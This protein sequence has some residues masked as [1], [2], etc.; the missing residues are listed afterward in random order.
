MRWAN[1]I[2]KIKNMVILKKGQ[3]VPNIKKLSRQQKFNEGEV[4]QAD[5]MTK[6]GCKSSH[7]YW[8][9]VNCC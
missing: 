6:Q 8:Q 7:C 1:K 2:L 9:F 4:T 5:E 3:Y